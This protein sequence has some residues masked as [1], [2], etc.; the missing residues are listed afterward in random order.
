[1]TKQKRIIVIGGSAAGPKAAARARRLDHD[2]KIMVIQKDPD[3]SMASCGYPYYVGG[4]FDDRNQLLSTSVGVIR[5][6]VYY[7]NA[8]GIEARIHT[9]AIEIDR[10]RKTVTCRDLTTD[11]T[12]FLE[13]DKL[14]VATG[15]NADIPN[16][17]GKDLKGITT[18][19]SMEDADFLR[20]IG[21]EGK[22][23]RAVVIGGGLIGVETCEALQLAGIEITVIEIL[24]QILMFLDWQLAKILENHIKSKA[25]NVITGNGVAQFLGENGALTAVKL[26]NGTELPCELAVIAVGVR[27]NADLAR[28]AGLKIGKVGGVVVDRYM[29]TSDPDIYAVGDC[30][31]QRHLITHS[32]TYAPLGD[33]ANL[34]GRVAGENA[35]LGNVVVF[36]GTV[37][38]GIC[39]IFEYAAGST[40]LS[41]T[42]A[43]E[44]GRNDIT[45]VVIAGTDKPGFMKGRMLVSK[46]VVDNESQKIIGFQCVGPG[47]VS[48][49]VAQAAIAIQ[50]NMT[51]KDLANLDLPYAPPF[52]LAIDN[53]IAC[54]HVMEN[55]LKGRFK[56]ISAEEVKEKVDRHDDMYLLD[57]RGPNEFEVAR[58]GL[59]ET[60]IPLGMLRKRLNE[61]PGNKD[62]EIIVYCKVSLRGYE[63][64]LILESQGW[65]NV[66][67]LEGGIAAWPFARE[68]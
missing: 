55:K 61:L 52:T 66:K 25:A 12:E 64:A 18:L 60:L 47:D 1:M 9:E 7:L 59:G 50:G 21:D 6:P 20:R 36:P 27:P 30:T 19:K 39:K 45:S 44:L 40:G 2:A 32:E 8:K 10:A 14:I 11:R 26:S 16:V 53:F 38:S 29:Q 22:I 51:V 63:A 57:V 42:K 24:P 49:Q 28:R 46:M 31:E 37:K 54:T 3:L 48:K 17:P 62:K 68:K 15:S 56:G 58:L 13:Y 33:L 23:K 4:F 34:E 41:E 67:V 35:V 5:N 43:R 65:K